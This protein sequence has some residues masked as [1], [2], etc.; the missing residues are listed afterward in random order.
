MASNATMSVEMSPS[1]TTLS[2]E[3]QRV[4]LVKLEGIVLLWLYIHPYHIK[5]SS[6]VTLRLLPPASQNKSRESRFHSAAPERMRCK[7]L[8]R[9]LAA[10]SVRETRP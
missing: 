10:S 1:K 5:A 7:E 4:E 6:G 9:D 8:A 3:S 2:S